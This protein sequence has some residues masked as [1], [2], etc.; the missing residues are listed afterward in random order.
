M[1]EVEAMCERVLIINRGKLVAN[2]SVAQLQRKVAGGI[3]IFVEFSAVVQAR[4]LRSLTGITDARNEQGNQWLVSGDAKTDVRKTLFDFA[5]RTGR[6]VLSM[7]Q[8]E[9]SL[10]E[11]FRELT[12]KP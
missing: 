11:I 2:D 10:E 3:T 1:Q 12:R 8:R 7:N 5:V 4:D 6:T 9:N